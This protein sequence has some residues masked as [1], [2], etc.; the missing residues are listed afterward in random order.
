M[1]ELELCNSC[2]VPLVFE[3][4][5]DKKCSGCCFEC[6]KQKKIELMIY[7]FGHLPIF[8]NVKDNVLRMK[9]VRYS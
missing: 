1:S 9:P 3:M 4:N 6:F 5:T 7:A 8:F 2:D